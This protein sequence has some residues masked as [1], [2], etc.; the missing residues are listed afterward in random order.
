MTS[1]ADYWTRRRKLDADRREMETAHSRRISAAAPKVR[2]STL[3]ATPMPA[4]STPQDRSHAFRIVAQAS[5]SECIVTAE[6]PRHATMLAAETNWGQI[7]G[8]EEWTATH[9][10]AECGCGIDS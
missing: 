10:D 7:F 4:A 9:A 5:Q 2:P 6:T 3:P 8:A 1:A